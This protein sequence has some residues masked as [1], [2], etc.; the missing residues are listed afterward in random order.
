MEFLKN[1]RNLT[2]TGGIALLVS[3]LGL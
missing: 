1:E 2:L 3:L